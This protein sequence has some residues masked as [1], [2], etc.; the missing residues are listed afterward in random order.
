MT[1][2]N[3]DFKVKHGLN[4]A[5]G[6]TFGSAVVVGTPTENTHATT[7][8]YVDAL[9]GSS[10][11]TVGAT[12]PATPS[13]GQLWFDTVTQRLQVYYDGTWSPM[14]SLED[15]EL[16]QEHIHDTSIDGTG[17]IATT[18]RDGGYYT[19]L[20]DIVSAGLY[21]TSSFDETWDGGLAIN[22]YS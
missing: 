12:A 22:A 7:K 19:G 1:T 9:S 11:V 3:K 20:G 16:L 4:V 5:E 6:G 14:A 17:L 13:N 18:F 8:A 10:T 2:V 21:N 15:A